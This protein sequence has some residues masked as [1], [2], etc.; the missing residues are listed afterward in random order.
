MRKLSLR[1]IKSVADVIP[2]QLNRLSSSYNMCPL[3]KVI[4]LVSG[5]RA[6]TETPGFMTSKSHLP[7]TAHLCSQTQMTVITFQTSRSTAQLKGANLWPLTTRIM[8]RAPLGCSQ[9]EWERQ[10]S[11]SH[12]E[13]PGRLRGSTPSIFPMRKLRPRGQNSCPRCHCDFVS[14]ISVLS[15]AAWSFLEKNGASGK[16]QN[17]NIGRKLIFLV[18]SLGPL[19]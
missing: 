5:S 15:M 6:G 11:D 10:L 19:V 16:N 18:C 3:P 8:V 1:E 2:S 17:G 4:K 12:H 9:R 13:R 7:S 14:T